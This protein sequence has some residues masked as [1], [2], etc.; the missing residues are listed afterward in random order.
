[1]LYTCTEVLSSLKLFEVAVYQRLVRS[2]WASKS[3]LLATLFGYLRS[4]S[5]RDMVLRYFGP[6][7]FCN[8]A[9]SVA[10][11]RPTWVNGPPR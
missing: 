10:L 11:A 5:S 2:T 1:M 8:G 9:Q 7:P 6:C 3:T 4:S